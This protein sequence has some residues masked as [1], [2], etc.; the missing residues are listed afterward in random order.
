MI[1][2]ISLAEEVAEQIRGRIKAGVYAVESQ[3]PTE[4]AL[5]TAFGVGRSSIREAIRMLANLGYLRVQQGVGTFVADIEGSETL[6]QAFE[7]ASLKDLLEV[8]QLLEVR[9]AEKAAV[10]RTES[11]LSEMMCLL[12][13]RKT[14]AE[15]GE[16]VACIEADVLFHQ[17]VANACGNPILTELY[18]TSSKHLSLAFKQIY[19]TTDV[20]VATQGSHELLFVAI[21]NKDAVRAQEILNEIIE[22]V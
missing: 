1:K 6:G 8:R 5:M 15:A 12:A 16:L 19:R 21:K 14:H 11:D 17:S 13:K 18:A 10:N 3:L 9:I 22:A 7:Q 2:K 20:F 4:T